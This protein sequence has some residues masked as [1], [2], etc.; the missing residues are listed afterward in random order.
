M[1]CAM[2]EKKSR[3]ESE[4]YLEIGVEAAILSRVVWEGPPKIQCVSKALKKVKECA[5]GLSVGSDLTVGTASAE[6]CHEH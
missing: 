1:T 5:V 3:E 2:E 6:S 4:D